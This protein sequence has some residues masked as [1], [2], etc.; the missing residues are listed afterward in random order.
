MIFLEL[1]FE[2]QPGRTLSLDYIIQMQDN[3]GSVLFTLVT[4]EEIQ[5]R[6]DYEK[7]IA[8]LSSDREYKEYDFITID[9]YGQ[10]GLF[11]D[12]GDDNPIDINDLQF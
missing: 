8:D 4:G 12:K 7:L 3:D 9:E 5:I 1:N 11:D 2:D 6:Y 10:Q